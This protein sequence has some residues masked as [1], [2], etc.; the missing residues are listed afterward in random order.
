MK[1]TN[2]VISLVSSPPSRTFAM[3]QDATGIPEINAEYGSIQE[4]ADAPRAAHLRG[5]KKSS[6]DFTKL[7]GS[8]ALGWFARRAIRSY[9][10]RQNEII[11][12]MEEM[13]RVH[14]G[15]PG[16]DQSAE[17]RLARNALNLSFASNVVL[18]AIRIAIAVISGSLSLIV[19]TMDA[20]LDVL[21]S[22]FMFWAAREAR[23]INKYKYPVGKHR[24]EPLGVVV[25]ST[26]MATAA[27]TLII[28]GIRQLVGG[29]SG[30]STEDLNQQWVVVGSTIFVVAMKFAM[31]LYCRR[32]SSPAAQA[33]ATDHLNDVI[34]NTFSLMGA[35]LGAKVA[36]QADPAVAIAISC[37]VLVSWG[38]QGWEQILTLIGVAASPE[39]LQKLTYLA[40]H[41]QP[42]AV[43]AVDT[44]RAY[45]IGAGLL[46][47]VDIVLPGDM[48]LKDAHDVGEDLQN[49]LESLP[50]V[51]RAFVHLD[52]ESTH[53]PEH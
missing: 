39:V 42:E 40:L 15:E 28:E 33:F 17:E 8:S 46:A 12:S 4:D 35:L 27:F 3:S 53:A 7:K 29:H 30:G 31:F 16:P 6:L 32:S 20:V 50:E 36:W 41:H 49:K 38:F 21:S 23:Q 1:L 9:Y 47:E 25:F 18:L 48:V 37:W 22:A 44:V 13:D 34:V 10:E 5:L 24:L 2:S 19:A 14:A 51:Y 45:T 26:I 43:K 11:E 52:V